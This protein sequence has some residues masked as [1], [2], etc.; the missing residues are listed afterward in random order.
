MSTT[1]ESKAFVKRYLNA[2]NGHDKTPA[3]VDQYVADS[4]P[5]LKQHIAGAEAAFPR[6]ELVAEDMFAEGDK[7]ALRFTMRGT[8]KGEF[9][10]LAPT[11]KQISVPGI[12]IYRIAGGKIAEHWVHWELGTLLKQLGATPQAA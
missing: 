10:G 1:E 12:I 8:H 7:V 3:L 6:Y 2:I 9:A 5:D 11:G 4:D